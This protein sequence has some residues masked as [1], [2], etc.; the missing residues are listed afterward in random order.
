MAASQRRS[1]F[2]FS[3]GR[4]GR[5]PRPRFNSSWRFPKSPSRFRE[6]RRSR[7]PR[8]TSPRPPR[9]R[10]PPKMSAPR[11][12]CTRRTSA[13]RSGLNLLANLPLSVLWRDARMWAREDL[14]AELKTLGL[15]RSRE[16][17][18]SFLSVP[19]ESFLPDG[20]G[21]L[22]YADMPLP[23]HLGRNAT[24]MPSARCLVEALDLLEPSADLRILVEGCRGATGRRV[25]SDS[26]PRFDIASL[27]RPSIG[28]R[29]IPDRPW[30]RRSRPGVRED[31]PERDRDPS[32]DIQRGPIRSLRRTARCS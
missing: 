17:E 8:R 4:I 32:D 2:P 7:R 22:A 25:R 13:S 19:Q 18:R 29:R 27:A 3:R 26:R 11:A 20:L 30:T 15:L 9:H 1:A 24:T 14:L 12:R 16:L 6:R 23:V 28:G 21:A 31:P 10:S 5:W